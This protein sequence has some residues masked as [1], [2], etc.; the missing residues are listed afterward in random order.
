MPAEVVD[1]HD[2]RV[3]HLRDELRLALEALLGFVAQLGRRNEL[4]G[5]V[6]IQPWVTGAIDDA[7]AAA[8]ELR[9]DLVTICARRCPASN[10]PDPAP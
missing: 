7:H 10:R 5:D 8:S 4:D 2:R 6:A 3:V 9:D 1:R